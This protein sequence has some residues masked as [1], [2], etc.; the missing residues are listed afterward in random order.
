MAEF[1]AAIFPGELITAYPETAII[2]TVRS[3]D[4]W[5]QSTMS[6]LG[7]SQS[8]STADATAAMAVM[9]N[10]Y[11]AHCWGNDFPAHGRAYFQKHSDLARRLGQGRKFMEYDV[12]TGWVPLCDL[13]GLP[14]VD[15]AK[16]FPRS[17]D[18][19]S[20]IKRW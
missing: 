9:R 20:G 14:A 16:A 19:V 15:Q 13:L 12:E 10:K 17:D 3:E 4:S 2:L 5:Y 1:P 11:Q 7:H 6:T 8:N 18:W